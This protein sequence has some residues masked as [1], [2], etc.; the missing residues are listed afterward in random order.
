MPLLTYLERLQR[1]D[2][3]IQMRATGSPKD[4]AAKLGISERLV[5]HYLNVIRKYGA[6]LKYSYSVNS[7][8]YVIEG[9]FE[10]SFKTYKE[11]SL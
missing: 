8:I 10:I 6:D 5:Y 4:L 11:E 2:K 1:I 7:Y 3:L 9:H